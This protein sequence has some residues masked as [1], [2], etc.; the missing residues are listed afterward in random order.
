LIQAKGKG[1]IQT[2]WCEPSVNGKSIA[3]TDTDGMMLGTTAEEMDEKTRRL[4]DWNVENLGQVDS[5]N[6]CATQ[7]QKSKTTKK[8]A[9]QL[10][11]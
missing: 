2:F 10:Q 4:V 3:T 6:Y 1:T 7:F 5:R 9:A 8:A 11:L